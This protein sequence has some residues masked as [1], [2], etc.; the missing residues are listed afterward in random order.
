MK[1][2][3]RQTMREHLRDYGEQAKIYD[4][5]ITALAN[6]EREAYPGEHETMIQNRSERLA[7]RRGVAN[8]MLSLEVSF[9]DE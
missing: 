1:K 3:E 7:L 6:G 5:R 9:D 8:L 2:S 4:D